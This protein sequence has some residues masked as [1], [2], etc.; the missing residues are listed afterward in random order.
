MGPTQPPTQWIPAKADDVYRWPHQGQRK[1]RA[2]PLLPFWI[3]MV[4]YRV[5][6]TS[7]IKPLKMD[8][9]EGSETS[10]K[11]NLTPGKYPKEN[12]QGEIYLYN[13]RFP[14]FLYTLF[15]L[16]F[17]LGFFVYI[18]FCLLHLSFGLF[19]DALITGEI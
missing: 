5:K 9:T 4:Y 10:A 2:I 3:F 16:T 13:Y 17:L 6:F 11:L 7:F 15:I 1:S 12:I 8:L 14:C 18:S 19:N